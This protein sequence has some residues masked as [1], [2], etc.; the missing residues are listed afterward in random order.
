MCIALMVRFRNSCRLLGT[1][2]PPLTLLEAR[3]EH[4]N[5]LTNIPGN[6]FHSF[7]R[8]IHWLMSVHPQLFSG[9]GVSGPFLRRSLH[10]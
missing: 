10:M 1:D 4:S 5:K 9:C 6:M 7:K 3:G 8:D 2:E